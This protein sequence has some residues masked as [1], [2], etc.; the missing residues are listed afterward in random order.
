MEE[1]IAAVIAIRVLILARRAAAISALL[2]MTRG[3]RDTPVAE[4]EAD[5]DARIPTLLA[6]ALD[7]TRAVAPDHTLAPD[8]ILAHD[9]DRTRAVPLHLLVAELRGTPSARTGAQATVTGGRSRALALARLL[10]VVARIVEIA[11][12]TKTSR[13]V[14]H[15][16]PH[17][18]HVMT[19]AATGRQTYAAATIDR[20][21]TMTGAMAAIPRATK[22]ETEMAMKGE[23]ET[24][25]IGGAMQVTADGQGKCHVSITHARNLSRDSA[26]RPQQITM[27]LLVQ[28]IRKA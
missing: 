23:T 22:G 14:H 2:P 21:V 19:F 16:R 13:V 24:A 12:F 27:K 11:L 7:H 1:M 4:A 20:T 18:E 9:L 10:R 28:T 8:R 26:F 6:P 25:T 17:R 3:T 5:E 15:H